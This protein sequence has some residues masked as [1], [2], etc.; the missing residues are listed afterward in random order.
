M[1]YADWYSYTL[2]LSAEHVFNTVSTIPKITYLEP[3]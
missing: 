2:H 1:N 3:A